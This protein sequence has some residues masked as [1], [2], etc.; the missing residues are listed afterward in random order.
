MKK[1]SLFG[2]LTTITLA[3]MLS[4]G[5]S[6]NIMHTG[7]SETRA[8]VTAYNARDVFQ[9]NRIRYDAGWP[10]GI[11]TRYEEASFQANIWDMSY[12]RVV[13]GAASTASYQIG[14]RYAA[15]TSYPVK[16]F[17][18]GVSSDVTFPDTGWSNSVYNRNI[19][20]NEGENVFIV[21][22]LK[23]GVINELILP[24]G[25]TLIDEDTSGGVYFAAHS[26]LQNTYLS[27]TG[28]GVHDPDA[29]VYTSELVY[30]GNSQWRSN[31]K[32][33]VSAT[34]NT[35]SIDV[36]YYCKQHTDGISQLHMSIN[37][38]AGFNFDVYESVESVYDTITIPSSLLTD[39]GFIEGTNAIDI[40]KPNDNT[41][42]IG[43]IGL[44]LKDDIVIDYSATRLEVEDFNTKSGGNIK[45]SGEGELGNGNWSDDL[46]VGD[47]GTK[48]TLSD[49]SQ[50]STDLSNVNF[51]SLAYTAAGTGVFDL[52][53]RYATGVNCVSYL[54]IDQGAWIEV[55]MPAAGW[56]DT[57]R[58]VH[59]IANMN[60][61]ARTITLTGTTNDGGWINYDFIDVIQKGTLTDYEV[62][63]NYA[64]YFRDETSAGCTA[65]NVS[66]IPWNKLES[67]YLTLPSGAKNEFVNNTNEIIADARARYQVLINKYS[68]LASD[69][70][71]VDGENNVVYAP[72]QRL[73][74][75][76]YQVDW[77]VVIIAISL[78]TVS[79]ASIVMFKKRKAS[80]F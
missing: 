26:D 54:R 66:L 2:I 25:V 73:I 67:E 56:W 65:Q 24:D 40:Y 80:I 27:Y 60:A 42:K 53:I 4:I 31:A 44:A 43:L 50:I 6:L 17:V 23:W 7:I 45:G 14:L 36:T 12:G 68:T 64:I 28:D 13:L 41:E 9:M 34:E 79:I 74:N 10:N 70:W 52:Y 39:N 59:I 1:Q 8:D 47:M 20:L 69:N 77:A 21:A 19:S 35:N 57:P 55:E 58:I 63:Y 15:G 37:G 49:S 32:F 46:Y 71:L 75:S 16:I 78:L 30:D 76:Q 11:S 38:G 5:V 18:N 48:S 29:F 61:G 62:A 22:V 33:K 51:L 3:T 72:P